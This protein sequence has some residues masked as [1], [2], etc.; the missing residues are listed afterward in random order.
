MKIINLST[1]ERSGGA[2]AAANRLH[3][4]LLKEHHD[5]L[6][7]VQYKESNEKEVVT[8]DDLI[9]HLTAKAR[10]RLDRLML[11]KYTQ[12][13]GP[14]SPSLLPSNVASQVLRLSP[15][16]THLHWVNSGFISLSDISRLKKPVVW[17][18]HDSWAFTGG[19]HLPGSCLGYSKSCGQC[20]ILGSSFSNDLSRSILLRKKE[21]WKNLPIQIVT[22]S[23]WLAK[24]AQKS[25]LFCDRSI[26]VIPNPLDTSVF[27]PHN[28]VSSREK[29]NLPPRLT[30]IIFFSAMNAT[31]DKN[32][33]YD[34]LLEALQ[35]MV[36]QTN[37]NLNEKIELLIAGSD[38]YNKELPYPAHFLGVV[39]DQ[40][41]MAM[42]YSSADVF[43]CPSRSENLPYAVMES[44]ACATPV[45]AFAIGGI[46]ELVES[47]LDGVLATPF[48]AEELGYGIMQIL[49]KSP[50]DG[51][52]ISE[53][54]QKK[55]AISVIANKYLDLYKELLV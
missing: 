3:H 1:F 30:K 16:I 22:P 5:S 37:F 33:G 48:S 6:M 9:M 27:R 34:L 42:A 4:G 51:Y 41:K 54:I 25:T 11:Q 23:Y 46:P 47:P 39:K 17:T 24:E 40:M 45:A 14:F 26:K 20:P 49:K 53:K 50:V 43:V 52:K 21:L 8:A 18:L 36:N 38:G 19:C 29:L 35:Y 55:Y 32:K 44:L 7:L 10:P 13:Q 28:K 31:S 2:A 12:R 15:D